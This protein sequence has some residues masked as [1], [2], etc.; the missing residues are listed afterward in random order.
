MPIED[1]V[2]IGRVGADNIPNICHEIKITHTNFEHSCELSLVF[3]CEAKR[4]GGH[5]KL[6]IPAL[7]TAL[8]LL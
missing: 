1:Q 3:L 6:D 4:R 8:D 2:Q 5:L 7:K